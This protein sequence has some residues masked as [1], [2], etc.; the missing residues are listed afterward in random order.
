VTV[1]LL[2]P[3][4]DL[5]TNLGVALGDDQEGAEQIGTRE[6]I[7]DTHATSVHAGGD[8]ADGRSEL[9]E[10]PTEP[11]VG[12]GVEQRRELPRA[13]PLGRGRRSRRRRGRL[14]LEGL[15]SVGGPG[16]GLRPTQ[17]SRH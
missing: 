2:D 8:R 3:L 1:V 10:Q 13:I 11:R 5:M 9:V 7:P 6:V 17:S 12:V 4:L 15:A 16:R 14:L